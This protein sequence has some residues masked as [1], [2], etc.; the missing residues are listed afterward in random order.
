MSTLKTDFVNEIRG[1]RLDVRTTRRD[2]VLNPRYSPVVPKRSHPQGNEE[3]EADYM[4]MGVINNRFGIENGDKTNG[5]DYVNKDAK[6]GNLPVVEGDSYYLTPSHSKKAPPTA[7]GDPQY[8]DLNQVAIKARSNIS[9]VPSSGLPKRKANILY[10]QAVVRKKKTENDDE[11]YYNVPCRLFAVLLI[12][13]LL[14]IVSFICCILLAT[15]LIKPHSCSCNDDNGKGRFKYQF[16]V[17][18]DS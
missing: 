12:I 4:E 15:G 7:S 11:I 3:K 17:C 1:E 14:A 13:G 5:L 18:F 16:I 8:E 10:E 6:L 2:V 9:K